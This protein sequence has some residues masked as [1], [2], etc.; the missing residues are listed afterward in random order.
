MADEELEADSEDGPGDAD[1]EQFGP[2][3][4]RAGEREVGCR[5]GENETDE[6]G[7]GEDVPLVLADFGD[8]DGFAEDAVA[9]GEYRH[10]QPDAQRC[11]ED[12]RAD[13]E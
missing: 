7:C 5:D 6:D 8:E 4:G 13:G 9:N 3:V 11:E 12:G 2:C 10:D 1:E